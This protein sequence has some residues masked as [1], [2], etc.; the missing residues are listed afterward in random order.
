MKCVKT[1][2]PANEDPWIVGKAKRSSSNYKL[3][4]CLPVA[5]NLLNQNF[6]AEKPNTVWL[7]DITYVPTLEAAVSGSNP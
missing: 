4:S 6:T 7:S 1:G 2:W 3:E 5:E